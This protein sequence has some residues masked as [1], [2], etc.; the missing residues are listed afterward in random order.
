MKGIGVKETPENRCPNMVRFRKKK[1]TTFIVI[2]DPFDPRLTP[3]GNSHTPI[4][5]SQ[6]S[7]SQWQATMSSEQT[8]KE[9]EEQDKKVGLYRTSS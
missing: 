9:R 8:K 4:V 5:R 2:D 3:R 1:Q 6:S 7:L